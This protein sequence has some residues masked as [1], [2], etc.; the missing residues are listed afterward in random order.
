[1]PANTQASGAS[2]FLAGID[3][4]AHIGRSR[5][6]GVEVTADSQRDQSSPPRVQ[7]ELASGAH[8]ER[9][10]IMMDEYGVQIV[11]RPDVIDVDEWPETL[12]AAP[13]F[14]SSVDLEI[15]EI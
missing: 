9:V 8:A 5:R 4:D 10:L 11:D 1:M 14:V 3:V 7:A 2:P 15:D 13:R 12:G 6:R